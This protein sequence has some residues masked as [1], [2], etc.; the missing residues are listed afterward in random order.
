M[1]EFALINDVVRIIGARAEGR[2]VSIGPGD[3]GAVIDVSENHQMVSSVDTLV[4]DVHFPADMPGEMVGYRALMVSI[5]DIAAMAATPPTAR[6]GAAT[7]AGEMGFRRM[8]SR[9]SGF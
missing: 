4:S 6:R 7:G 9:A 1:D 2:W 5:S 8:R 3:D